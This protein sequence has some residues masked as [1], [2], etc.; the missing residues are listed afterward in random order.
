LQLINAGFNPL[1]IISEKT[2]KTMRE[3]KEDMEKGAISAEQVAE[4]FEIATSEGGRFFGGMEKASQT[5]SGQIS[6]LKDNVGALGRSLVESLL[7]VLKQIVGTLSAWVQEFSKLD[8]QQKKTIIGLSLFAAAIGPVILG[9]LNLINTL[10]KLK[11]AMLFLNAHPAILAFT[12]IAAAVAVVA[13]GFKKARDEANNLN[14]ALSGNADLERTR[15][16]LQAQLLKVEA[17]REAIA[18]AAQSRQTGPTQEKLIADLESNLRREEQNLKLI[19]DNY[20]GKLRNIQSDKDRQAAADKASQAEQKAAEDAAKAALARLNAIEATT[21]A[22]EDKKEAVEDLAEVIVEY[23]KNANNLYKKQLESQGE[24]YNALELER[25]LRREMDEEKTEREIDWQALQKLG[26]TSMLQGFTEIGAAL[27]AQELTWKSF[28]KV[29][30]NA[31][32][33]ILNA[34]GAELAARAALAVI[35]G[36]WAGAAIAGAAAAVAFTASGAVKASVA[37]LA[38]GGIV[39]PRPGGVPVT[40]AEAGVPEIVGPL[41]KVESMLRAAGGSVDSTPIHLVVKLDSKPF[42]DKIFPATK[43]RTVL[44][45]AASVV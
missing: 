12:A 31:F 17:A 20:Q 15:L 40:V 18:K 16:G 27:V 7:P 35:T 10:G 25:K 3:L 9:I 30:L 23:E 32:A 21:A 24:I 44:I 26:I 43:N 1:Q 6:T 22:T 11:V 8:T 29:A 37:N 33:E 39:M 36:N 42:L 45:S 13:I 38:D 5:F 14:A 2:G 41:D 4:A 34:I 28:A 19:N